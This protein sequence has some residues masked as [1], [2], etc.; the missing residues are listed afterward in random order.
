MF[1]L[2]RQARGFFEVLF[3]VKILLKIIV[4][5]KWVMEARLIFGRIDG[6]RVFL[7]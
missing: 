2:K 4:G 5:G 7:P 6:L 3:V 1:L